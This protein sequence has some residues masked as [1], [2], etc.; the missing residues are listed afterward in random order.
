MEQPP[1][2]IITRYDCDK[3]RDKIK[4][5]IDLANEQQDRDHGFISIF[6]W[7]GGCD[8]APRHYV[9]QKADGT[10]CGW[11]TVI[12]REDG[13]MK[14]YYLSEI[15]VI[16]T[17]D[18]SY[19]GVGIRLQKTLVEDGTKEGMDFIYLYP[20]TPEVAE[21]YVKKW[22]YKQLDPS[23]EHLF[24]KLKKDPTKAIIEKMKP[25]D[26]RRRFIAEAWKYLS[27]NKET[28]AIYKENRRNLLITD[29][30]DLINDLK[31][32][33]GTVQMYEVW[34]DDPNTDPNILAGIPS[35]E[36]RRQLIA[37]VFI[38]A[39][40]QPPKLQSLPGGRRTRRQAKRR[41][42]LR[43]RNRRSQRKV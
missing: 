40:E 9:A 16:R 13:G 36:D 25:N 19:K 31:D 21:T 33:L 29:D 34:E 2:C 5:L 28:E 6:P 4:E 14:Y 12:P 3:D 24:Y 20:L 38:R 32:A 42:T 43:K 18:P 22:G 30:L 26:S 1:A 41:K 8:L 37:N 39:K 10:I 23:L 15:S 27:G 35:I 17:P 11:M 7:L